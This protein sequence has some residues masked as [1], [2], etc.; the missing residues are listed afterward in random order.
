MNNVNIQQVTPY[1]LEGMATE[2]HNL[3]FPDGHIENITYISL[4][5]ETKKIV[6]F[7]YCCEPKGIVYPIRLNINNTGY[8]FFQVGRDGIYEMQPEQWTNVNDENAEEKTSKV[9]L[10][11]IYVPQ[12]INFT[13][14]YVTEIN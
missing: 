4:F 6:K 9:I 8:K 3:T 11:G 2:N 1:D 12:G 7:G 14:E 10:T 5:S 13:F